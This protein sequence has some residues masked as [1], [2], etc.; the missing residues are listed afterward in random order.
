MHG[1]ENIMHFKFF[2]GEN[3][4]FKW[5]KIGLV[6]ENWLLLFWMGVVRCKNR[7]VN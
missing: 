5:L 4:F 2:Q 3:M 6:A 1:A 7:E